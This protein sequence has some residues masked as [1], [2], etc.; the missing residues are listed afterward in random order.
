MHPYVRSQGGKGLGEGWT[1]SLGLTNANYYI[2][3]IYISYTIQNIYIQRERER[4]REWINN[5]ILFY[6]Q[7]TIQCPLI[8][9]NE[10]EYE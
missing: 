9:H 1:G 3:Y 6:T 4:E 10:R 2:E 7:E 5:K 8:N